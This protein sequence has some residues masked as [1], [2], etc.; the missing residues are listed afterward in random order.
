MKYQY[1][2]DEYYLHFIRTSSPNNQEPATHFNYANENTSNV[3][4]TFRAKWKSL[5][6]KP[7][8]WYAI[9]AIGTAKNDYLPLLAA[10]IPQG[11]ARRSGP[12]AH[13]FVELRDLTGTKAAEDRTFFD[14]VRE[15]FP[16]ETV[17]PWKF[18]DSALVEELHSKLIEE[19]ATNPNSQNGHLIKWLAWQRQEQGDNG[20]P[21]NTELEEMTQ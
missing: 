14:M 4:M 7:N 19:L 20:A 12:L 13:E 21:I 10:D 16:A 5:N 18:L 2:P 8:R 1:S 6:L 15:F 11:I 9:L 3:P 17:V